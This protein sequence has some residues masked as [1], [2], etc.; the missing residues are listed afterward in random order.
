MCQISTYCA[1]LFELQTSTLHT[2]ATDSL[3]VDRLGA[4]YYMGVVDGRTITVLS[5]SIAMK[6]IDHTSP[7]LCTPTTPAATEWSVLLLHDVICSER[8]TMHC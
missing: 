7:A 1:F 5:S 2:E 4:V 3:W 8:V 6:R